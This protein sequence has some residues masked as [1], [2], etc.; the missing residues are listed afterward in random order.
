MA[1][2]FDKRQYGILSERYFE[3]LMGDFSAL[4]W[5][6]GQ[7]PLIAGLIILRWKSWGPTGTLYFVMA[8]SA[9]WFGCIN[10]C[11]E[12]ARERVILR[13]ERLFGLNM[14]SYLASK[15]KILGIIGLVEI[16][17]FTILL[18]RY[19]TLNLS[20]ALAFVALFGLY[21]SGMC[22]GLMLSQ[23]CGSVGK[24]VVAV[25]VVIIPQI[26]FSKFV[27]PA[28]TLKGMALTIEKYM[29][30]KWGYEALRHCRNG[31]IDVGDYLSSMGI[32]VG[33]SG[34]FIL[35]TLAHQWLSGDEQ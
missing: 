30:V 5:M 1:R 22:L 18:H 24:A 17:I 20:P 8:L 11:R 28:S 32:L 35:L 16:G 19:I 3:T 29:V 21:G 26:V 33:L 12:I 9:V 14:V 15:M 4:V 6:I 27:L 25:P 10:A 13:R 7:G 23:W 31:K 2:I 34:L